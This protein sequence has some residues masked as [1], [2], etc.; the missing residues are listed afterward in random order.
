MLCVMTP[1]EYLKL[2][3]SRLRAEN[4]EVAP[5]VIGGVTAL[6]GY[7]PRFR[8]AW[9]ATKLHLFTVVIPVQV[10]TLDAL[11]HFTNDALQYAVRSKGGL[12]GFQTGVAAI[13]VLVG[14]QVEPDAAAYAEGQIVKRFSAFAWPAAVDLSQGRVYRH[15]GRVVIGSV[16]AGWMRSQTELATPAPTPQP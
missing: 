4:V 13:P 12:R 16:Y 1:D 6:V 14:Y 5:D 3:E 10:V 15:V 11:T 9:M 8:L 2:V 7:R